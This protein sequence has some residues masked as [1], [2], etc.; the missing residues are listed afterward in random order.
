MTL[1][2]L[3]DFKTNSEDADFWLIRKGSGN[4]VG[5]PTKEYSPEHIGVTI[6]DESVINPQYLFYYFTM[7]QNRGIFKMLAKGTT[8]LMNIRISDVK[9]I[10][11]SM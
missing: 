2:D 10:P 3:V 1:G 5:K 9:S 8:R 7:L 4:T 6:K 11:V